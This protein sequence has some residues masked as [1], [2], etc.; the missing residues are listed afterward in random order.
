ML[1]LVDKIV[2]GLLWKL[3]NV[4]EHVT[5]MNERYMYERM[6]NCF[7]SWSRDASEVVHGKVKMFDDVAIEVDEVFDS[8][9]KPCAND[10]ACK[11]VLQCLFTSFIK[12]GKR[13]LESH[14]SGGEFSEVSA[15]TLRETASVPRTNVGTE[16]DLGT[17]EGN[18]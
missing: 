8:L 15:E 17:K 6:L 2:T 16:R 7:E 9:V 13:M 12:L 11:D 3:L 4:K 5:D 10:G 18:V 1:D 14:L